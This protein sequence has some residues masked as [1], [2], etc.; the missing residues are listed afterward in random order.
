M[1]RVCGVACGVWHAESPVCTF[2]TPRCVPAPR[3]HVETQV[4]VLKVAIFVTNLRRI[5]FVRYTY[6]SQHSSGSSLSSLK[7]KVE[8]GGKKNTRE[9]GRGVNGKMD[10][11]KL[12]FRKEKI[13]RSSC[14][15]DND[16]H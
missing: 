8:G 10:E 7:E 1:W 11:L 6:L 5:G 15:I 4:C 14:K 12:G 3:A 16:L 13:M 9:R 2:K